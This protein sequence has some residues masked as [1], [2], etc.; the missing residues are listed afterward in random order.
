MQALCTR[1]SSDKFIKQLKYLNFLF[2]ALAQAQLAEEIDHDLEGNLSYSPFKRE[3]DYL[4][5]PIFHKYQAQ[6]V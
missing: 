1:K 2:V 3:T 5:H 6:S 4:T